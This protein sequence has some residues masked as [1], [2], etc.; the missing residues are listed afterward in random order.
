M[1]R[2]SLFVAFFLIAFPVHA[3]SFSDVSQSR[4]DFA[5]IEDLKGRGV[6]TG[7][8]DGTFGP[9]DFVNRAEAI[10]IVVR[11]VAN[12]S[13][14][15]T[16]KNCFPDVYGEEWYVQSVCYA[17][18]LGWIAGYPD[19]TFQPVRTVAK[20]EFLKILLSFSRHSDDKRC[21]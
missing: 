4:E 8:P 16:F 5:A 12:V 7:R 15:P 10:T 9:D 11:A 17:K 6:F 18:D 3:Q 20:A 21:A 1:F 19:G 2:A 13:N 14:L